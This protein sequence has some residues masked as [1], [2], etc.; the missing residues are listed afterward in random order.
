MRAARRAAPA[1]PPPPPP[2]SRV[3]RP[4]APVSPLAR[5]AGASTSARNVSV[6]PA[7]TTPRNSSHASSS[8]ATGTLSAARRRRRQRLSPHAEGERALGHVAVVAGDHPPA[9]RVAA[10]AARPQRDDHHAARPR[11]AGR[12]CPGR[13]AVT[14]ATRAY[15]GTTSSSYTSVSAR[16]AARQHRL[17]TRGGRLQVRVG[18][19]GRRDDQQQ[20]ERASRDHRARAAARRGGVR[21]VMTPPPPESRSAPARTPSAATARSAPAALGDVASERARGFPPRSAGPPSPGASYPRRSN[22]SARGR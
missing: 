19:G 10:R 20:H 13:C 9:H 22:G 12:R 17:P 6:P 3:E 2:R 18:A 8:G 21:S 5:A 15:S 14:T 4:G 16:G 11:A 1:P 7:R